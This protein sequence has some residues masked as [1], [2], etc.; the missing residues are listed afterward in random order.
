MTCRGDTWPKKVDQAS[1]NLPH[2]IL[3]HVPGGAYGLAILKTF[4]H[5]GVYSA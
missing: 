5:A 2:P 4:A 1:T 3:I